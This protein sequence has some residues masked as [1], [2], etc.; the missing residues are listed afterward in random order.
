M[1]PATFFIHFSCGGHFYNSPLNGFSILINKSHSYSSSRNSSVPWNIEVMKP[2]LL[3][4]RM[5]N[6]ASDDQASG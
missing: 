5:I 1:K 4:Q 6:S 2:F 3:L